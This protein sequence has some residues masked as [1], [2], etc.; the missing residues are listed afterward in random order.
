MVPKIYRFVVKQEMINTD[1]LI[2]RVNLH[3]NLIQIQ[4]RHI[5]EF[6]TSNQMLVFYQFSSHRLFF[7]IG[8]VEGKLLQKY[9]PL[10]KN[11]FKEKFHDL[12][13][14][15]Y[16]TIDDGEENEE[17]LDVL[18]ISLQ[19]LNII[20]QKGNEWRLKVLEN[21]Q[22]LEEHRKSALQGEKYHEAI[23]IAE[24][25][26]K[27]AENIDSF[28][29]SEASRQWINEIQ[30]QLDG[31]RRFRHLREDLLTKAYHLRT[32]IDGKHAVEA[33]T[34]ADEIRTIFKQYVIDD[35]DPQVK[36]EL[37]REE[38]LSRDFINALK[39]F[40]LIEEDIKDENRRETKIPLLFKSE[41][42]K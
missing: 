27:E 33:H 25:I 17:L 21:I 42:E 4:V 8:K 10:I 1:L 28:E 14:I 16:F 18:Q 20:K 7:W 6:F 36:I 19:E 5:E 23:K 26:F 38:T 34:A 15:R 24:E 11:Q 9:I 12:S 39:Q 3:G 32:L 30:D 35:P 2:H 37:Q 41:S 22:L 29:I 13:I 31:E 40:E